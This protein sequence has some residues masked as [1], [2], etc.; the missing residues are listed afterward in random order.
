MKR[1]FLFLVILTVTASIAQPLLQ[2]S[3]AHTKVRHTIIAAS[4]DAAPAGGNYLPSSFA[5]VTL[6]ARH[7][8]AFD[9]SVGTTTGV[10]VGDGKTTSTTALGDNFGSV[11][12]PYITPNGDVVFDANNSDTYRSNGKSIVP[13][14]RNGDP[15]P[16]GGILSPVG[17]VTNDNGAI[18][19]T[20]F[21]SDSNA[22]QGIFRSDGTQTVAIARDDISP[23][24]GGSFLVV[25]SQALNDRG[26]VAFYSVMTGGNSDYGIFRGEG[27]DLTPI[28]VA[29]QIGPEGETFA[30]FSNPVINNHG[31]I[32]ATVSFTN[33]EAGIFVRDERNTTAIALQNRPAPKGGNYSGQFL[34]PTRLNDQ[35]EVGFATRLTGGTSANGIFRGDGKSTTAI[36]LS[37]TNAP[38]TTGTFAT[39]RDF[40]LLN[41][42]RIVFIA[43]LTVGVGGVNTSNNVGIWVGTSDEDLQLVARSGDI[44]NG[45]VLTR[46]P[47]LPQSN[48]LD[49][50][51]NSVVWVGTFGIAKAV[52]LSRVLGNNDVE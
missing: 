29:N 34:S 45:K 38:G 10:F 22:T 33:S 18:A 43:T 8:V 13:L 1:A 37:G 24:T 9:A 39:F 16:G 51:E 25:G 41:N 26:Q 15:A 46:L 31:Q 50:N 48:Q 12:N 7:D 3:S 35:G 14:V 30:D 11:S 32:A 42:G 27:Q 40:Q 44:I 49:I 23:P 21:V 4:G 28:F 20:A 52:I 2:I 47:Q 36:A 19:F 17:R 5:N 6:N